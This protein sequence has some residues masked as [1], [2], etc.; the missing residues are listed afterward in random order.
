MFLGLFLDRLVKG[1]LN[2][3]LFFLK[4]R[5]FSMNNFFSFGFNSFGLLNSDWLRLGFLLLDSLGCRLDI[6]VIFDKVLEVLSKL[7]VSCIF[8]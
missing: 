3:R 5:D 2:D 1:R 8:S 7:I 6:S 4:F